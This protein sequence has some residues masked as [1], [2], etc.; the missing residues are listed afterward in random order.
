MPLHLM[1]FLFFISAIFFMALF[2]YSAKAES[3]NAA[4][5]A[6]LQ[7]HPSV[8][9]AYLGVGI[10]DE[11]RRE[12]FSGYFPEVS[13]GA[14]AGRVYGDNSTS[15]GL[16]VTRGAAYSYLGEASVTVRQMLFD[17]LETPSRV[18]AAKV[19]K[20]VAGTDLVDVREAVALRAAQAYVNVLRTYAGLEML[21][22]HRKQVGDYLSR[23]ETMV[24]E[25][26]A[27]EAELQ[28]AK[29]VRVILDS[30]T[31]EY[32]GQAR[33]A[34]AHYAEATGHMPQ[35]DLVK[36]T[37]RLDL[38][39]AYAEDA[40]SFAKANH[41]AV[42]SAELKTA[43]SGHDI[44]AERAGLLPGLDGELSYL[45]S[46]KD[47]VIGGEAVDAK[48]VVRLNWDFST[49]GAELARIRQK[50]LEHQEAMAGLQEIQR[51]IERDI[52]LAY[53]EFETSR[54]QYGLL[55]QREELNAKLFETYETQFE[56]A[57]ITQLQL[58]QA[59]NQLFNTR[60]E[61]MNGQHRMLAAEFSV[62]AS[63]GR[64]QESLNNPPP[65]ADGK[66]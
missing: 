2:N 30:I 50:K 61:K 8:E 64:L 37:P 62:L 14:T 55:G 63:V 58:M 38:V 13:L 24:N 29:E 42:L 18:E 54:A 12:E 32:E 51:Q 16:S 26:A 20:E 45:K 3:L 9:A 56:G 6:A 49:G 39:P 7:H 41:P 52:R 48:A 21:R 11:E 22:S 40:T 31:Q 1:K 25:G 19:R 5:Q 57:R 27:D 46:D 53:S 44:N 10:A 28:Q 23:I 17:G 47:D 66:N 65:G 59:H 34:E 35:G 33:A 60:L 15:R 4:V 36:P 43:A